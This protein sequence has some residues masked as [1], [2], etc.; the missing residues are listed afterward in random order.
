M[1]GGVCGKGG[2]S[3]NVKQCQGP[4]G[5]LRQTKIV[6]LGK[7]LASVIKCSRPFPQKQQLANETGPRRWKRIQDLPQG[8][9]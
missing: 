9:P 4:Q 1:K 7:E 6:I 2:T 5:N 3:E 8:T